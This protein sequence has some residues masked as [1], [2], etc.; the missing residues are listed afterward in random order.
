VSSDQ[1]EE[2][3]EKDPDDVDE[4][5][6]ETGDLDRHVTLRRDAA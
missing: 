4:V 5:P 2:R 1:I 3:E 6:V